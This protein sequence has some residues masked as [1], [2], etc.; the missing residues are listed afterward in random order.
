VVSGSSRI[1]SNE[2]DVLMLLTGL[3][4]GMV[5]TVAIVMTREDAKTAAVEAADRRGVRIRV[6]R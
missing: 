4:M 1:S 2:A 6:R 3:T 5:M